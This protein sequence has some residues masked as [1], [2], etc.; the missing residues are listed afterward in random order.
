M[1]VKFSIRVVRLLCAAIALPGFSVVAADVVSAPVSAEPPPIREPGVKGE[2]ATTAAPTAEISNL[3]SQISTA[4]PAATGLDELKKLKDADKL[5]EARVAGLDALKSATGDQKKAIED[6][7]GE[8]AATLLFSKRPMAEKV[9]H[10]VVAGDTLGALAKHYGTTVDA[11]RKGNNLPGQ[12]IRLGSRLRILS[13]KF[14]ITVSKTQNTL[15]L[16][17]NDQFLKRYH[18]GTGQYS[19]TPTGTFS[20]TGKVAQPTWYRPDGK[21]IPYGDKENLLGTHWMS[22]D[23]PGFGLHGTWEPDTIGKQSSQGCVRLAN[24]DIEELFTLVPEGT[25]VIIT[26]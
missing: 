15:T 16:T 21:S 14:T 3:K 4:P 1:T 8:I 2:T 11:I 22:I 24:A 10:T 19:T 6:F 23:V 12:V 13:G 18:V 20:I 26:E 7:L 5:T 25:P 17:L 9:E